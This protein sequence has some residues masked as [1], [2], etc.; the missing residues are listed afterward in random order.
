MKSNY[1]VMV[2]YRVLRAFDIYTALVVS[3][4]IKWDEF[5]RRDHENRWENLPEEFQQ[6]PGWFYKSQNDWDV[7]GI[8]W[9]KLSKAKTLLQELGILETIKKG[10]NIRIWYHF[11]Q[12]ALDNHLQNQQFDHIA[13]RQYGKM[14]KATT[15][16]TSDL[17]DDNALNDDRDD[18]NDHTLNE[19]NENSHL[20]KTDN[21]N[22]PKRRNGNSSNGQNNEIIEDY[23]MN[24]DAYS[25]ND[26]VYP[27]NNHA[28]S[29]FSQMDKCE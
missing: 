7:L 12:M 28:D 14:E 5:Y 24:D 1:A 4:L 6:E 11:D 13:F 10:P 22:S 18:E 21:S 23:A 8:S 9:K 19:S 29:H 20:S 2:P 3:E 27:E 26:R 16:S 17:Y 25:K 15:E